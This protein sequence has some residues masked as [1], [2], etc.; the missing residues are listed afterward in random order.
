MTLTFEVCSLDCSTVIVSKKNERNMKLKKDERLSTLLL[1]L[2]VHTEG[3]SNEEYKKCTRYK[4]S[5][6]LSVCIHIF[7][8]FVRVLLMLLCVV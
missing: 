3:T 1:Y 7:I 5:S 8:N 6:R 4:N 2:L